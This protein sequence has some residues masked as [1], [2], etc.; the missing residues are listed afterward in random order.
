MA[1][2]PA[3]PH[4]QAQ[5]RRDTAGAASRAAFASPLAV[6]RV[7]V[8]R[9]FAGIVDGVVTVALA[10]AFALA[11]AFAFA[12][13]LAL[14]LALAFAAATSASASAS[15]SAATSA[16]S[17][18][19]AAAATAGRRCADAGFG[20]AAAWWV[21]GALGRRAP[22]ASGAGLSLALQPVL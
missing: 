19:A 22:V 9:A 2:R 4:H 11:L 16:T 1:S 6:G 7:V 5:Q 13:A 8:G 20:G 18:S 14:A 12:F 17:A 15:A 3:P 21:A 10:F